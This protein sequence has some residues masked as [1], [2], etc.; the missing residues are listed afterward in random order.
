MDLSNSSYRKEID[1]TLRFKEEKDSKKKGYVYYDGR[2]GK[3]NIFHIKINNRY[4][5]I[6]EFSNGGKLDTGIEYGFV[7]DQKMNFIVSRKKEAFFNIV[8]FLVLSK[9]AWQE[10]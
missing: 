2:I 5:I 8:V 1:D 7:M 10:G 6:E 9:Q 4:K 3:E